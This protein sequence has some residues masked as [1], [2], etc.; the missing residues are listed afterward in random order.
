[1][2]TTKKQKY[3]H[4]GQWI[5]KEGDKPVFVLAWK[6]KREWAIQVWISGEYLGDP[7]GDW[8]MPGRLPLNVAIHQAVLQ[9]K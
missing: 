3:A 2:T 6:E 1:M 8:E 7:D 5:G 9:S 4:E